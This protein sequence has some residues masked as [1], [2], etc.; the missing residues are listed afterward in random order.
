[1]RVEDA[2]TA[3]SATY[4]ADANRTRDLDADVTRRRFARVRV[5]TVLE[6]GCGTGKNT[7][8]YADVGARVLALDFS[9][10]ML[11]AARRKIQA[12]NVEFRIADLTARWPCDDASI[13]LVACNLVLE[14]VEHLV[15]VFE[16]AA[17]CLVPG[18]RF[19]L[20]ELHPFRQYEGTQARFVDVDDVTVH[21]PAFVHHVSDFLDAASRVGLRLVDFREWW[22]ADDQKRPPRLLTVEVMR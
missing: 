6:I 22:H 17:R 13:D 1:M 11:A 2:Y 20:S 16:E 10:G 3:W 15:P 9:E 18:G 14:H 19:Y 8:L 5:G 21:V 12:A 7:T 4:D